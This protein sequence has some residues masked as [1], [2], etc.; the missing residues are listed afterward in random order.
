MQNDDEKLRNGICP[1]CGAALKYMPEGRQQWCPN[2]DCD[3]W[4]DPMNG[5]TWCRVKGARKEYDRRNAEAAKAM[6]E[7]LKVT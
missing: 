1:D 6:R 5:S 4:F 2:P 7:A 3:V